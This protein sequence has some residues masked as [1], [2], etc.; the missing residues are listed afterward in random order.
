MDYHS[1]IIEQYKIDFEIME[2][3][4][5][6]V[7]M[8]TNKFIEAIIYISAITR[9]SFL[10]KVFSKVWFSKF[11]ING[12]PQGTSYLKDFLKMVENK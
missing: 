2:K 10:L 4:R 12:R 5:I 6:D 3:Y 7:L 11:Y 1:P 8:K 9:T